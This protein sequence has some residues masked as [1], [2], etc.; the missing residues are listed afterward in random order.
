[1]NYK[2]MLF[3]QN[4]KKFFKKKFLKT[5]ELLKKEKIRLFRKLKK[6]I[7]NTKNNPSFIFKKNILDLLIN[8]KIKKKKFKK[9]TNRLTKTLYYNNYK[10]KNLSKDNCYNYSL[11][12]SENILKNYEDFLSKEEKVF[13]KDFLYLLNK[14]FSP[15]NK[16][17]Y[18]TKKN[19]ISKTIINF[20]EISQKKSIFFP[21][22]FVITSPKTSLKII[23]YV[24]SNDVSRNYKK[25]IFVISLTNILCLKKSKVDYQLIYNN[26]KK[27]EN[28]HHFHFFLGNVF[29]KASLKTNYFSIFENHFNLKKR[30]ILNKNNSKTS[31]RISIALKKSQKFSCNIFQN[32][33]K[34]HT[35]SK[36]ICN[37]VLFEKSKSEFNGT[38]KINKSSSYSHSSQFNKNLVVSNNAS[39]ISNPVLKIDNGKKTKCKHGVAIEG[40]QPNIIF[41]MNTRGISTGSSKEIFSIGFLKNSIFKN[42]NQ[43]KYKMIKSIL[44][45]NFKKIKLEKKIHL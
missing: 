5:P 43:D 36:L 26:R 35:S 16:S 21:Y 28:I 24:F 9:I 3:Y 37:N 8:K 25:K 10:L 1:M 7:F 33:R 27:N 11:K 19:K 15:I 20:H 34:N 29:K 31:S 30:V 39:A 18:I 23:D 41:Y 22:T 44:D 40:I 32:H 6:N 17:I 4:L 13:E 38:I 14:I 2:N 12:N 42:C 45:K